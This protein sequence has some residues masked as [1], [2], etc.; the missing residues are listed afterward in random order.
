[1]TRNRLIVPLLS[2]LL[3]LLLS[4]SANAACLE[5]FEHSSYGGTK[6][7][8]CT[9]QSSPSLSRWNDKVSSIKVPSGYIVTVFEHSGQKGDRTNFT[10]GVSNVGSNWNDKISSYKLVRGTLDDCVKGYEDSSYRG[11]RW[12]FCPSSM[13]VPSPLHSKWNDKISSIKVPAGKMATF[14]EHTSRK[15]VCRTYFKS[16]S[17]VG[18]T[19]ND[20]FSSYRT[21]DF[22]PN[23]FVMAMTSDPQFG[24]CESDTCKNGPG[25]SETANEWHSAS[26]VKLAGRESSFAGVVV[27]GDVTNVETQEE[28]KQF[29]ADY[30]ERGLNVYVGYG[31]HDYDNYVT[32]WC[33]GL[34]ANCSRQMMNWLE[35]HAE[36][37][38]HVGF[39]FEKSGNSRD[40]SYAYSW[41]IGDYRFI[42]LHNYPSYEVEFAAAGP[43][44]F[45]ITDSLAW[46]SKQVKATPTSKKIVL[47]MHAIDAPAFDAIGTR[48]N[49]NDSD[50]RKNTTNSASD[51][52]L[53]QSILDLHPNIV[54]IFGGHI[55]SR[56]NRHN[57]VTSAK[58]KTV[59]VFFCG[60][61]MYNHYLKVQFKPNEM[62]IQSI[63]STNGDVTA[64]GA[65]QVIT[66]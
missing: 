31:N 22:D 34:K 1:M 24:Y 41:D 61:A 29:E 50:E 38:P 53:F 44:Y 19:L 6:W 48:S 2:T 9:G 14:C 66:F 25:S 8:F 27:N 62:R 63:R 51:Y 57:D 45:D 28:L 23:N 7:S 39:D 12:D 21:Q 46:L 36:S 54:A 65:E 16:I 43:R 4:E 18:S 64:F 33:N 37:I 47:N 15:G 52:D 49:A 32:K 13:G 10:G 11:T 40:G 17:N 5:M 3:A 20:E 42:Q 58:G 35:N 56:I 30:M 26:I 55:H 60:A 59:P